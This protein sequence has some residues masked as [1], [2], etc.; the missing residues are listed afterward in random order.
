M[1]VCPPRTIGQLR[2]MHMAGGLE[3][4]GR[5]NACGCVQNKPGVLRE[6]A[7]MAVWDERAKDLWWVF[8]VPETAFS[9]D[10]DM[11]LSP[12]SQLN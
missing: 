1:A 9:I 11:G 10:M 3:G 5:T 8:S 2:V 4:R 12:P 7:L 6:F